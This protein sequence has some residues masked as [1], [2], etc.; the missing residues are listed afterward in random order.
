LCEE[1]E[2]KTRKLAESLLK[3]RQHTTPISVLPTKEKTEKWE[4][5]REEGGLKEKGREI[6]NRER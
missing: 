1:T 5:K 3:N 4:G 6:G 2:W